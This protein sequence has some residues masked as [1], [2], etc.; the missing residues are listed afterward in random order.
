MYVFFLKKDV[1]V[2]CF[3]KQTQFTLF[4]IKALPSFLLWLNIAECKYN[5]DILK[6]VCM[7]RV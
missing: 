1:L 4:H 7:S 2:L 6:Y 5:V 3:Q